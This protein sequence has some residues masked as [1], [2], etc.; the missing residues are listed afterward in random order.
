[1]ITI[2]Q[3]S[4]DLEN[5]LPAHGHYELDFEEL[6]LAEQGSVES[7]IR[8]IVDCHIC[9]RV[10]DVSCFLQDSIYLFSSSLT[11]RS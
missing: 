7:K 5:N 8:S 4:C 9:L 1:M 11:L 3:A 10:P 6:S 2:A